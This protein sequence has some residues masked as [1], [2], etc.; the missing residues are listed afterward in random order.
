MLGAVPVFL[1]TV[2]FYPLRIRTFC[3]YL[4]HLGSSNLIVFATNLSAIQLKKVLF[5][6]YIFVLALLFQNDSVQT[7]Q[8]LVILTLLLILPPVTH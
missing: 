7:T 8:P 3:V 1:L 6:D 2:L 4:L 5:L